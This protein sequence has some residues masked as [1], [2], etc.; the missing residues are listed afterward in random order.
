MAMTYNYKDDFKQTITSDKWTSL[1]MKGVGDKSVEAQGYYSTCQGL[2][3]LLMS[4]TEST[5]ELITLTEGT[6]V[7]TNI[8]PSTTRTDAVTI[9]ADKLPMRI[10]LEGM[11][12]ATVFCKSST[13]SV[14]LSGY[15]LWSSQ[16]KSVDAN[17]VTLK[18]ENN[19]LIY[20]NNTTTG[21]DY[22]SHLLFNSEG[23]QNE[24]WQDFRGNAIWTQGTGVNDEF[25]SPYPIL[26]ALKA[27][28]NDGKYVYNNTVAG[29]T[30]TQKTT[31]LELHVA[32]KKETSTSVYDSED[33]TA[34]TII[35]SDIYVTVPPASKDNY[36]VISNGA[37]EM[38]GDKTLY[39]TA[40]IIT[41]GTNLASYTST[42]KDIGVTLAQ[43][44]S[45]SPTVNVIGNNATTSM[46][47][48]A[49]NS[50]GSMKFTKSSNSIAL[51]GTE[52]PETVDTTGT[53]LLARNGVGVHVFSQ[54]VST[55]KLFINGND[56]SNLFA[57]KFG[58]SESGT[59]VGQTIVLSSPNISALSSITL[60]SA[61]TRHSGVVTTTTQSFAGAKTF[62]GA[63]SVQGKLSGSGT[64]ALNI[65][66]LVVSHPTANTA[67]YIGITGSTGN[68]TYLVRDTASTSGNV[69]VSTSSTYSTSNLGSIT[70]KT[71]TAT[72]FTGTA[73][74]ATGDASG[75]T[76]TSTYLSTIATDSTS[77][78]GTHTYKFST[79]SASSYQSLFITDYFVNGIT[80]SPSSTALTTTFS[81]NG[82]SAGDSR[83]TGTTSQTIP[84]ATGTNAG[85][86]TA[87]TQ[88]IGGQKTFTFSTAGSPS[89][90][91]NSDIKTLKN[92]IA[93]GSATVG[94]SL[95]VSGTATS[96][97]KYGLTV[98]DGKT[99]TT[100]VLTVGGANKMTVTGNGT[101]TVNKIVLGNGS[102]WL[103]SDGLHF[104]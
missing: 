56:T 45:T 83:I 61:T 25:H 11:T 16:G 50:S 60:D 12:P 63:V 48:V 70:A 49:L 34:H 98:G 37:Q 82:I 21:K 59:T 79:Q 6:K 67:G 4:N 86:L 40:T 96:S 30:Y 62:T 42:T 101:L 68:V 47:T 7:A 103:D 100:T 26:P 22:T 88:D 93:S 90:T 2:V 41:T 38:T 31:G 72:N 27:I 99:D 5:I 15:F 18:D 9:T 24:R 28:L 57:S 13:A 73:Q 20:Y 69:V 55:P 102:C 104:S 32:R 65:S 17:R 54:S 8:D 14:D 94:G 77:T 10:D 64:S 52:T 23:V 75:N 51:F 43:G 58:T 80:F 33:G 44:A 85:I 74:K 46:L 1:N 87:S 91:A 78:T 89:I 35:A 36:G 66:H 53:Q 76:I 95:A 81:Y 84:N 19:S 3:L 92:L 39:G 29:V 71:M 97:V